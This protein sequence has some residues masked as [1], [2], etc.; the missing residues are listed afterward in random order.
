MIYLLLAVSC[1]ALL[2]LILKYFEKF[3]IDTLQGIVVN[4]LV[5]GSLGLLLSPHQLAA[6]ELLAKNWIWVPPLMGTLFIIIFLMIAKT[7]QSIGVSVASVANKMS[8]IIPVAAAVA[9][10]GDTLGAMKI[11]GMLIALLSVYLTSR[12]D[13]SHGHGI[14]VIVLPAVVFLGSGLIDAL[15]NYT[16]QKLLGAN[17]SSVFVALSFLVAFVLGLVLV[18]IKVVTGKT[19]LQAKAL[20]G[21]I[22][23]GL[24]NYFSIWCLVEALNTS[25]YESSILYPVANMGIVL[26]SAVGARALF[27]EKL[28]LVNGAGILLAL[29]ATALIMFA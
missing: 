25:G 22:L 7:A 19:R 24:P 6:G 18:I 9:L 28:S 11:A 2:F 17:E 12:R 27:R 29:A 21:G 10:Y 15:V 16:Q 3:R 1:N 14:S 8:F 20:L 26:L 4:Y 5:A 23:L 13:K